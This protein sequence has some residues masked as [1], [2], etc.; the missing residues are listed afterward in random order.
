MNSAQLTSKIAFGARGALDQ[1]TEDD[2]W[3]KCT[4]PAGHAPPGRSRRA[5]V[6]GAV[7]GNAC[8]QKCLVNDDGT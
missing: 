1:T 6:G 4:G 7:P 3:W 8:H 5:Y 2:D